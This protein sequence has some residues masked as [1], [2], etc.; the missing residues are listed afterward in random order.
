MMVP[1]TGPLAIL[2]PDGLET[3]SDADLKVQWG[4]WCAA[5]P[6]MGANVHGNVSEMRRVLIAIVRALQ[7]NDEEEY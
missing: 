2:D 1:Y 5:R 7:T 6:G 4:L 3:M